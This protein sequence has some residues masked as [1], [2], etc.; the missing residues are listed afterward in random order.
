M[1][2]QT[3]EEEEAR[4]KGKYPVMDGEESRRAV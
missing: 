3:G 1:Q 2:E 4:G